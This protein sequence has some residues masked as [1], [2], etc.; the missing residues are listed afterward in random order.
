MPN[1]TKSDTMELKVDDVILTESKD[2]VNGFNNFFS[3]IA[4]KL[5]EKFGNIDNSSSDEFECDCK[6]AFK[7]NRYTSPKF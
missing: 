4:S 3:N 1:D 2:I 7:V 5:A 6:F